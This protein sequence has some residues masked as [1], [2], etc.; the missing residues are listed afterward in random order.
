ML[1]V[2]PV[3]PQ[4]REQAIRWINWVEELGGIGNHRL[5]VACARRVVNPNELSRTYEL[6][7]PHDEDERGWPMSPNHLFKRVLQ[8]VTWSSKPEA[9]FWCEPDCIPLTPKWLDRLE[10]EYR[11]CRQP[12]MGAN[13]KVD[14]TP[15][16]MSGNAIYP[17]NAMER[18]YNLVHA[19]LA[20]FDVVAAEQI[21]GQAHWTKLIQHV[22]QK[23]NG[24]N[25]TFPDQTSVDTMVSKDAVVFHQNKDGTLIQRLRERLVPQKSDNKQLVKEKPKKVAKKKEQE[26]LTVVYKTYAND[27]VWLKYSLLS[28][29]KQ[30][31][32]PFKLLIYCHDKAVDGLERLIEE[33]G[34]FA[35]VIPVTYDINGYLKQMVVKC[36]CWK[37]IDTEYTLILDSDVVFKAPVYFKDFFQGTKMTWNYLAKNKENEKEEVWGVWQDAVRKMT[38]QTMDNYY[39][40]NAFPFV[41]KTA[42]LKGAYEFFLKL[43]GVDYNDFCKKGL[44][45]AR[46]LPEDPISGDR[47]KF[48]AM[49]KIFEEFEYLGWYFRNN[50]KEYKF[51]EG[52]N[53]KSME[54]RVQYWSHGGVESKREE[55]EKLLE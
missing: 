54:T 5:L 3:G 42:S 34:V 37:D 45:E 49:A 6:Y 46:V 4:D 31:K 53:L 47:G 11:N 26:K 27:L 1:V 2:L 39:M 23:D 19:D 12:F 8:H 22:W 29:E 7:V 9:F 41:F 24:R 33:V 20:A 44:E 35:K 25:F 38:N 13:V 17:M 43:H 18:A 15:E 14:N 52:P 21:I 51:I 50:T 55:I 32:H 10:A 16:H 30:F 48:P 40:Y 28:L 36:M